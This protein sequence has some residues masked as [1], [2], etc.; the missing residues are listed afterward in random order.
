MAAH[1]RR[2]DL[3]DIAALRTGVAAA[4]EA[5]GAI[6]IL[7]NNAAHDERHPTEEMGPEYWDDRIAALP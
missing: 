7:I 2:V 4:R 3:T 1:F 5:H 6:N